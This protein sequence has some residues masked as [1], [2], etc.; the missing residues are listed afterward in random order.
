MKNLNHLLERFIKYYEIKDNQ[1]FVFFSRLSQ[2][3]FQNEKEIFYP[4]KMK[5]VPFQKSM[6]Y[7]IQF[8]VT[9]KE[10]YANLVNQTTLE[11]VRD[12]FDETPY[13]DYLSDKKQKYVYLP[14]KNNLR[15]SFMI[16][17][18]LI[19]TTTMEEYTSVARNMFC[20]MFPFVA[21]M[22]Q[23]DYFEQQ[24]IKSAN[25]NDIVV[26]NAVQEI[27]KSTIFQTDLILE[28]LDRGSVTASSFMQMLNQYSEEDIIMISNHINKNLQ[29]KNLDLFFQNRYI[30]G[31][32]FAC[33]LYDHM[34][35]K[36]EFLNLNDSIN[37]Y[38]VEDVIHYLGLEYKDNDHLDLIDEDYQKL[39]K[40]YVKKI[41]RI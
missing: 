17:H 14:Y 38:N 34:K 11:I 13:S 5:K 30:I 9:L 3:I 29:N 32:L 20:E 36:N 24:H 18:E 31:Y 6:D 28:F 23:R 19:H 10:E 37:Q 21:E 39:E 12:Q 35:D 15:D 7:S 40:S 1:D 27:N 25:I 33:Y 4:K 41:K 22:L 16:T 8:L 2:I 26:V